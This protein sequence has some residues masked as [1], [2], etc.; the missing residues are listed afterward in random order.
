MRASAS[1]RR[2]PGVCTFVAMLLLV[3]V[4]AS[5]PAPAAAAEAASCTQS[6]AVSRSNG[7]SERNNGLADVSA[8]TATDVWAD[9]GSASEDAARRR[10]LIRHW[11]GTKW[12][13]VP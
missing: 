6:W 2:S 10:T 11:D 7:P 8:V 4:A 3:A 12:R 5:A 9:G 1:V 13:T